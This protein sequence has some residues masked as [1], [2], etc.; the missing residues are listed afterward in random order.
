MK[1]SRVVLIV[2]ALHVL[3][4]GGIF[5]FEGCSRAKA[6]TPD[7][8]A[9]ESAPGSLPESMAAAA[10]PG[11]YIGPAGIDATAGLTPATP[12][13]AAPQATSRSYVVR[14]GDSLWKIAKAE[15]VGMTELARANKLTKNSTLHVG[16]KL[17]IPAIAKAEAP[18]G[19]LAAAPASVEA[20]AI[21]AVEPAGQIYLVKA[22]DS[23]WK[24]AKA[25]NTSVSALKQANG[26]ASDNLKIGQKIRLP[27]AAPSAVVAS[28]SASD[29]REPG[30]YQENGQ[31]VHYVDAG[32]SLA[33]IAK[34]YS[35]KAD[36]LARANNIS[37]ARRI[38]VGQRLVIPT[39][40][41]ATASAP[42][43]LEPAIAAPIVSAGQ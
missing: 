27:S 10:Q 32:E 19:A 14:K 1:V 12:V 23:L 18:V 24:I 5:V 30:T 17:Q 33:I 16:Q 2:V 35:V 41:T 29:W 7:M 36:E 15:G 6:P 20:G 3:V 31:T 26:L 34:K 38:Q 39:G 13:A 28:A 21:A 37:D 9:N 4:I 25:H 42:T 11:Q 8:A 40:A 22:G 43:G